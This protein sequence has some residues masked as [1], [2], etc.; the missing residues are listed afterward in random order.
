M[1]TP[2]VNQSSPPAKHFLRLSHIVGNPKAVPPI[3]P[4]IPVSKSTWWNWVKSGKAPAPIKIGPNTTVWKSG[5]IFQFLDDL[6]S[7][8]AV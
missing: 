5:D 8:E 7:G 6:S 3:T 4:I 1:A 2:A